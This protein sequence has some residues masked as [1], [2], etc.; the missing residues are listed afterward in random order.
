MADSVSISL[1]NGDFLSEVPTTAEDTVKT[2]K[3]QLCEIHG[4]CVYRQKLMHG[5]HILQNEDKL[6]K[7]CLNN[8]P[9]A[10]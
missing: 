8:K 3:L 5:L 1:L 6:G 4:T 2:L 9:T 10:L 7:G